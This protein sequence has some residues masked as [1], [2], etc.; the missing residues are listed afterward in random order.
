[1]GSQLLRAG[2]T[3]KILN[4]TLLCLMLESPHSSSPLTGGAF[5][6]MLDNLL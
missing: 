5:W 3:L 6:S 2:K 1:M 4:Q